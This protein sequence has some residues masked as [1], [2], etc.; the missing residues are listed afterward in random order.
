MKR[1]NSQYIFFL[2]LLNASFSSA[3][4]LIIRMEDVKKANG[5]ILIAIFPSEKGFPFERHQAI[6][7]LRASSDKGNTEVITSLPLGRYAVALFQDA[8]RDGKLNTN[9]LGMPKEGYGVSNNAINVFS[10]PRYEEAAFVHNGKTVLSI[11]M[12]Y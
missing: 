3:Q 12:H 6:A 10:A 1:F 2:L 8:N 7:L 4:Q 5:D 11:T 9:F